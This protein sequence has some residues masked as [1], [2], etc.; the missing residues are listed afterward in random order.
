M[1]SCNQL[2]K[3]FVLAELL[4]EGGRYFLKLLDVWQD[5]VML[6]SLELKVSIVSFTQTNQ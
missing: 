5:K 6:C 4:N 2:K 3:V 1:L